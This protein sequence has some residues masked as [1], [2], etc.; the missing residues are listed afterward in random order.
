[1]VE[2]DSAGFGVV[3]DAGFPPSVCIARLT[4][5]EK[6]CSPT[7]LSPANCAWSAKIGNELP[8]SEVIFESN[9]SLIRAVKCFEPARY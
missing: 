4:A 8:I 9:V 7:I 1:M 5:A 3:S 6:L 2:H